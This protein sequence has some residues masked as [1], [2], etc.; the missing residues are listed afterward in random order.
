VRRQRPLTAIV[1]AG[2]VVVIAA[3]GSSTPPSAASLPVVS[4]APSVAAPSAP[5]TPADSTAPASGTATGPAPSLAL[6][7]TLLAILPANV[8]GVP[9]TQ[10]PDSFAAAAADP[11]FATNVGS[12]AFAIVVDGSDLA[13]GVVARLRP[14]R[15]SDGLYRDWRDTYNTGA[16]AQ[17]GGVAGN[18]EADIG[19]RTVYIATCGGGLRTYHVYVPERDVIVSLFSLGDRRFGEQVMGK[20]RP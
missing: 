11:N 10:E 20:L 4:V 16:C 8:D 18:A 12:A 13:S 6:D 9:V 5:S 2:L 19:G 1:I 15:F 3:C 7:E 14:G 17:A